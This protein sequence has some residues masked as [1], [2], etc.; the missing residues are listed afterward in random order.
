V[1]DTLRFGP[2]IAIV[3]VISAASFL[4]ARLPVLAAHGLSALTLAILIGVVL[5]NFNHRLLGRAEVQPGLQFAQKT[6]LRIGVA[7][8]GLNLSVKEIVSLGP[9]AI[10]VDLFVVASTILVGW[11]IGCRLLRMDRDTVILTSAGCAICG[12]AAVIATE[13]V[14][15]AEAHKTAA[16]V[17]QVVL[18]GTL[19]MLLYPL[20]VGWLGIAPGPFGTYVGSTVHEVAQVVAIGKSMGADSAANAVVVKLIRVLLLAP[21]LMVLGRWQP[22]R[23]ESAT[24]VNTGVP[25]FALAFIVIAFIHPSLRLPEQI[26]NALRTLDVCLLAAAMAALGLDTTLA[27]LRVVGRDALLLGAI[28]F[29]YLVIGGGIA[30]VLMQ[31]AFG[32]QV[33]S[34]AEKHFW[35]L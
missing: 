29:G 27:K 4:L 21:Y 7:L 11:W 19:A 18:F 9:A 32:A 25:V 30:N 20:L 13:G 35:Q 15:G 22:R 17:G 10:C 1:S 26:L 24:R 8:Y 5:G 6:L 33:W 14:L 16:A 12:A 2:G 23:N 31:H 34:T 28:L 3:A